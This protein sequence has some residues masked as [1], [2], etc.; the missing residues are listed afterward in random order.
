MKEEEEEKDAQL[1]FKASSTAHALSHSRR[2]A[3]SAVAVSAPGRL[4]VAVAPAPASFDPASVLRA[5]PR[6]PAAFV[7][8]ADWRRLVVRQ[9][10]SKIK[11]Q[12]KQTAFIPYITAGDPGL[13][14]TAETLRLLDACGADVIEL[15]MPFPDPLRGRA[16]HPGLC[17]A[18][19]G[20]RDEDRCRA[21]DAEG[22]KVTPELSCPV[23]LVSYLGPIVRRGPTFPPLS[24]MPV[25]KVLSVNGVPG[26]FFLNGA[27]VDS[28]VKDLLKEIKQVINKPVAAGF[29]IPTPDHV[30][31]IDAVII[32]SAMAQQLGEAASPKEGLKRLEEYAIVLRASLADPV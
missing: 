23:V 8:V 13:A 21:G 16:S 3:S 22:G 28:R 11:E 29:G 32:G 20:Q 30:R 15:G 14:T 5:P 18:S 27:T 31:R 7:P 25:C 10:L 1:G 2:L 26:L 4:V 17:S 6:V 24:N 12:D 9:T 19:A